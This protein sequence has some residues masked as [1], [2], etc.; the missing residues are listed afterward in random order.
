[1]AFVEP[2]SPG[3]SSVVKPAAGEYEMP[4][5]WS[6]RELARGAITNDACTQFL[7]AICED[8]SFGSCAPRVA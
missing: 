3:A 5:L 8:A 1:M 4:W 2:V 6:A 7:E